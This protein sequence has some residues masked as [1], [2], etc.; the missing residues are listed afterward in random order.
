[1]KPKRALS[2]KIGCLILALLF[3]A[4]GSFLRAEDAPAKLVAGSK[5][6]SLT[7]GTVA[8]QNITI[9]SVSPRSVM[10]THDGGMKSLLLRDLSPELQQRFG[11]N[12][13]ADRAQEAK[14]SAAQAAAEQK[15]KERIAAASRNNQNVHTKGK[16]D[17]LIALFGTPPTLEASVDFRPKMSDYG[18]WVR[19]QGDRESC[20]VFA[21]NSA[22]EYQNAEV[23]GKPIRFSE[24]FIIWATDSVTGNAALSKKYNL[25][26]YARNI[27]FTFGDVVKA[28]TQYGLLPADKL[29]NYLGGPIKQ[30]S[31][32]TLEQARTYLNVVIHTI[33]GDDNAS[34]LANI[35][36]A[37][38]A[39]YP[40]PIGSSWVR[41][42]TWRSGHLDKQKPDQ[43]YPHAVTL[44][45][46]KC[47][48]GKIQ[49]TVFIFK[50][51]WG[52]RWGIDG[53]GT[54]SYAYLRQNM[55]R[56]VLLDVSAN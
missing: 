38:N 10:I 13:E 48:T 56:C 35:I 49:D 28:I 18:L 20:S 33:P 42:A 15:Q 21:I 39:G 17:Q 16:V 34:V 4:T 11:Y 32:E 47:E 5:L 45:G 54:V 1:M 31:T 6:P 30:P 22:I 3:L 23:T 46:Y 51:S 55:T 7:V 12:P 37:I 40:V 43:D 52:I 50:N 9:R 2:A 19:D 24:E 26:S 14:V 27:D 29:P 36:H 53:Y 41:V 25:N 8:Y 44:V